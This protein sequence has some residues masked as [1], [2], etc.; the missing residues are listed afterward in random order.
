MNSGLSKNISGDH[1][2]V[3]RPDQRIKV[4]LIA[5]LLFA[6]APVFAQIT[7]SPVQST[8]T[9]STPTPSIT[10]SVKNAA[11]EDVLRQVKEKSGYRLLYNGKTLEGCKPVTVSLKNV[12]LQAALEAIF[13]N[14]PVTYTISKNV[15]IIRK[16]EDSPVQSDVPRKAMEVIPV[17]G[18]VS[19]E[20]GEALPGANIIIENTA[21]RFTTDNQGGFN[22]TVPDDGIMIISYIG[23]QTD[24]VA[25]MG[26]TS[27]TIKLKLL[28]NKLSEVTV[29]TGYQ[30]LSKERAT[31]SFAK[32]D[33]EIFEAR[34]GTMDVIS[35]LDGLVPGLTVISGP[36]G[37]VNSSGNGRLGNG[38]TTQ[39]SI[40]RGK[41]SVVLASEP[42]YVVNGLPVA[43]FSTINPDDIADITVLKD[44]AA[45]AIWGA[46]AA[47]GVIVVTTKTGGKN[48]KM[49]ISYNGFVNFMGKPDFG[50]GKVLNSKQYIQVGRET[51]NP[52]QFPYFTL[53]TVYIAPHEQILYDQ[54]AGK[55]SAAQ[56]NRS[57]DSLSSINNMSQIKDLLYRNA[58]T[59]S[60]TLSLSG[61]MQNYTYYSSFSNTDVISNRPGQSEKA[62]RI[63]LNQEMN[64]NKRLKVSLYTTLNNTIRNSKREPDISNLFL[65][66]QLFRDK[67]GNNLNMNYVQGLSP[68]TRVDYQARSR[69]NLDY[70]P[71]DEINQGFTKTN[72]LAINVT[73]EV[74]LKLIR[75]LSFQGTYGYQ[76]APG[77]TTSYDD[78]KEYALRRELLSFTVA[79]S[80]ATAPVYYLPTTGGTYSVN[81]ND[82]RSWTLR[83]QLVYNTLIRDE[84]DRL[85]IQF[86]QE[87]REQLNTGNKTTLRGYDLN[88]Q[89]YAALDYNKLSQGVFG[90]VSSFRSVFNELPFSSLEETS[91]FKSY[92][93]LAN[94]TFND[95]YSLDASWRVDHSNLIGSDVSSQNK[96]VYSIGARWNIGK[97][98][99]LSSN[100]WFDNLSLRGTYGV[101]GNSPYIGAAALKDI[102]AIEYGM[103]APIA[104]TGVA[105]NSPANTKL[106]WETTK[107]FNGGIDFAILKSRING[108]IEYYDK[109]TTN[110]LG[111]VT[112]NPLT[113]FTR[114]KGNIGKL[115][116]KGIEIMLRS[117]NIQSKD[118]DWSSSLTFSYNKNKLLSYEDVPS[119]LNTAL[120]K[121]G[122]S[123]LVGY[124]MASIFAYNY[125]GLDKNG[126]P[127]IRLANGAVSADPYIA[128]PE[129]VIYKGTVIPVY[130]GGFT[131]AFRYKAL[132]LTANMIYSLGSVMRKDINTV[133]S[134]RITGAAGTFSA[135]GLNSYFLDRWQKTGDEAH[136]DIPA[137]IPNENPFTSTRNLDYY[138]YASTNVV[139]ASYV[140]LRDVTFSYQLPRFLLDKV[141]I[142][143]ASFYVQATNFMIWKAN[144]ADIDPEFQER[145][146][147]YRFIPPYKHSFSVGTTINF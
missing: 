124:S 113:G 123:Y 78:S 59:T 102:L 19:G 101:T 12:T 4:I 3:H 104:G 70:N 30:K 65:P 76:K 143:S 122:S 140:K 15:I 27:F 16:I 146:S 121:V 56:A 66:Y 33:M 88:L 87:T 64:V 117:A 126:N 142:S 95:K 74:N 145:V 134:G 58:F 136:T 114:A 80:A 91:R 60:H 71:M 147:G 131:N 89:N 23:Y 34:T 137:Y 75:G 62:F 109:T 130:N 29:S 13:K 125:A 127:Q 31:G 54:S 35:R 132:S 90:T 9:Q 93:A 115:S 8:P 118:F 46:R 106:G 47:N 32:P 108:S 28:S 48:N 39:S 100:K 77:L 10:I 7:P 50:Y 135:G 107:T 38:N 61:G 57:L 17:K 44:A 105:V 51:F 111:S 69:I 86:G 119:F 94:Y 84:K 22:T 21:I 79:P 116:N 36:T 2:Q 26:K 14:Q 144:K 112:P 5:V 83:N 52:S 99:F 6:V 97:E 49:R 45:T 128:K 73:G 110:L 63:N 68:E 67:Q 53:G 141:K 82:Q 92:F 133:F 85:N 139:S 72:N 129:D 138:R 25:V 20:K 42:L 55:I 103:S 37:L 24:T 41:S 96:P 11:M 18:S 40:I 1:N 43:D 81:N 120:G 98:S